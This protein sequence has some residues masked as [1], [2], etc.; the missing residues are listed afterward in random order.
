VP[1]AEAA[2]RLKARPAAVVTEVIA[3]LDEWALQRWADGKPEA[4]WLRVAV[5][6]AVLDDDPGSLRSELRE[7]IAQGRLAVERELGVLSAALR[8][9]PVPVAIPLG[10]DGAR[11]RQL[12][13]RID[14]SVEPALGLVMLTRTLRVAGQEVLAERLLRKA[15]TARPRE[16]LLYDTLGDLLTGQQ[17]PPWAEAVECFTAA[18]ILRP[19]LGLALAEALLRGGRADEGLDLLARMVHEKPDNPYLHFQQ[20]LVLSERRKYE[21][22]EAGFRKAIALKPDLAEAYYNLD[23]ALLDQRKNAEAEDMYRRAIA[24]IPENPSAYYN[25]GITLRLQ[26]KPAEAETAYRKVIEF[27]PDDAGAYYDLGSL[28]N[29]QEKFV[30]AETAFR[31]AIV[32]KPDSAPAHNNLGAALGR[33]GKYAEEEAAY[34]KAIALKPDYAFAYYNLGVTLRD[35]GKLG[36]AEAAY[37][38]VIALKPDYAKAHCNLGEVLQLQGRFAE[39]LAEFRCGHELGSKQPG[40][41]SPSLQW[42]RKAERLV[43]LE[44]KLPSILTND[45]SP[46]NAGEAIEFARMCQRPYQKRYAASA[47]L[48]AEAF[49]A[50]PKF[51]ADWQEWHRYSAACS[52]AMAAAGQGNDAGLLPDKVAAMFRHWAL[53]WLRAD[54]TTYAKLVG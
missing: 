30:D 12:T 8:P 48:H 19:D 51:A 32:L 26:G 14:P 33:Q 17:P 3:A 6:A 40:W 9:V 38:E 43:E 15:L 53:V 24:L 49:T 44:K 23:N 10:P 47:R 2:A 7:I 37:R 50:E 16:V 4:E 46:A 36:D 31:K 11:L 18:R 52:A 28:L 34:R 35:Q 22:A 1:A 41:H 54:L 21:E 5:L 39:S 27:K 25:L 42:V 20:A 13:E 45:S 29:D